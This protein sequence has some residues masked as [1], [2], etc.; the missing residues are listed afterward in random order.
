[1][2]TFSKIALIVAI[3]SMFVLSL[4]VVFLSPYS[5]FDEQNHTNRDNPVEKI[6]QSNRE[7]N[8]FIPAKK[9]IIDTEDSDSTIELISYKLTHINELVNQRLLNQPSKVNKEEL[10]E[11]LSEVRNVK[12]VINSRVGSI[13]YTSKGRQYLEDG[14]SRM[15]LL[16]ELIIDWEILLEKED[17]S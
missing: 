2:N 3:L 10:D 12:V 6:E 17:Q 7:L 14:H 9:S 16:E 11:I 4:F 5:I 13:D 15:E 8:A 1:M